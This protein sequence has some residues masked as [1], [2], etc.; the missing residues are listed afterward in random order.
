VAEL[1]VA[2]VSARG[3][4]AGAVTQ[5][6]GLARAAGW[7]LSWPRAPTWLTA[8]LV[9]ALLIGELPL[10]LATCCAPPQATG[11]GTVWFIND[12]AQYEAAMR[13]GAE[14]SSWL[15]ID[16]FT[17][18]PHQPAFMFPLYVGLGKLS[19][20]THLPAQSLERF[21]E[22]LA[23]GLLVV[24]LWHFCHV[25]A[26]G[27]SAARA[28][29]LLALFGGGFEFL[30]AALQVPYLA[31]FSYETHNFGLLLAAP[32]VPLGMA[33]TLALAVLCLRPSTSLGM[34]RVLGAA[35]LGAAV[36]LLH[37]FHAP[38]L[39]F[40]CALVGFVFWRT[41]QGPGSLALGLS[42]S[43]GALPVLSV[44]VATFSF[45]PFWSATYGEQN[46]LPSP[47]PHE[48]LIDFGPTLLLALGGA[49]ALR[50]RVAPFGVLVWLLLCLM[51]MYAPVPYQRRLGFGIHPALAVLAGNALVASAA[52]LASRRAA[53]LRLAVTALSSIGT[54]VVVALVFW[55]GLHNW[56]LPVYRSTSDLDS[57]AAW[58]ALQTRPDDVVLANWDASNYLAPRVRARVYGG[59]PV[60]TLHAGDRQ[61]A[62]TSVFSHGAAREVA[63]QFGAQWLVFGP[64]DSGDVAAP[65]DFQ[66]GPVRVYRMQP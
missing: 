35:A 2:G 62:I 27:A 30:L 11:L 38:V 8:T 53:L 33:A 50:S 10:L 56:P 65:A 48:L 5:V 29:V 63:R 23:R 25:F 36:A 41:G 14:Q 59:H 40:A 55:S 31:N 44:T 37:P 49:I 6:G 24:A 26:S 47:A 45:D 57:A 64:T 17:A 3:R 12:F 51:A 39:L 7:S 28:A 21:T 1:G 16:V 66:S 4:G 60:A 9:A 54:L 32:H 46:V 22:V 58:L 52:T 43:L 18:E 42:A 34:W 20:L 15:V 13:Q 61:F 19:A